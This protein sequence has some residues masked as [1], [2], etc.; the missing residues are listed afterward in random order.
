MFAKFKDYREVLSVLFPPLLP[1]NVLWRSCIIIG[2]PGS[3]KTE[4]MK[5]IVEFGVERYG[6]EERVNAVEGNLYDVLYWGID[7]RPVQ[8]LCCDDFTL[9][10]F[11]DKV[12][13]DYFRVRHIYEKVTGRSYGLIVT[14]LVTHRLHEI[15]KVFRHDVDL[16]IWKS[17]PSNP[18]DYNLAHRLLGEQVIRELRRHYRCRVVNTKSYGYAGWHSY[19]ESG[20]TYFP[21]ARVN[22]LQPAT[23]PLWLRRTYWGT[24]HA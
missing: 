1:K 5:K 24:H 16:M 22:Y 21:R 19:G 6:G 4:T 18:Y 15:E 3:G 11:P 2:A 17:V 20:I 8:I 14:I 9:W 7:L 23:R 10:R 12:K 13:R